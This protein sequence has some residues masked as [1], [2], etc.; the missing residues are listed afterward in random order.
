MNKTSR[1]ITRCTIDLDTKDI[2]DLIKCLKTLKKNQFC[3]DLQVK[4]SPSK[5]GF[6]IIAWT[7]KEVTLQKLIKIRRKA[8]D[9]KTRCDLDTWGSGQRMIN[10]LF[11]EKKRKKLKKQEI[12][13]DGKNMELETQGG[14]TNVKIS[15]GET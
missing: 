13:L 14:E 3:K 8:G 4:P 2:K 10:V 6:H 7:D 11:T 1:K 9:D 12:I 15:Y 5:R